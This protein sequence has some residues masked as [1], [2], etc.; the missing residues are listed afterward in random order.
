M[1][2]T[3][4][5]NSTLVEK[6]D[7]SRVAARILATVTTA[8]K[9]LALHA[10]GAAILRNA[11]RILPANELDL[12]N[13][14]ENGMS[15]GMQDRL[16]LDFRRLEALEA[17]VLPSQIEQ[18]PDLAGYLKLASRPEWLRV[19]LTPQPEPTP[20]QESGYEL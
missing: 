7:A 17:A 14:R 11:D 3:A 8:Q 10:I 2:E 5:G 16:R 4:V 13:A 18:L 15:D 9:N 19:Q 20:R 6:L 12:A 1:P